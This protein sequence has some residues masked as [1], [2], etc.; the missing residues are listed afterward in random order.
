[1]LSVG[2]DIL[3]VISRFL[4]NYDKC[5]LAKTC[6]T[7]RNIIKR[8]T[9]GYT[10]CGGCKIIMTC[11]RCQLAVCKHFSYKIRAYANCAGC[12][13][14]ICVSC[15]NDYSNVRKCKRCNHIMCKQC[16]TVCKECITNT[17]TKKYKK[18]RGEYHFAFS[19]RGYRYEKP[20]LYTFHKVKTPRPRLRK[21]KHRYF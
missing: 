1:M 4:S 6:I 14:R 3:S 16:G 11:N 15:V 9:R 5:A 17:Y 20:N 7:L 21:M 8:V 12:S 18:W 13:L 19:S 2:P 10:N